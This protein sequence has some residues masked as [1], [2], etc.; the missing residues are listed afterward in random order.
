MMTYSYKKI[1][2]ISWPILFGLIIHQ[3]IGVTD[4]A[5]LGRLGAVELGA[6]ALA[7]V[8]YMMIF[9]VALGFGIGVQIIVARRN[10][11]ADFDKIGIVIYQGTFFLLAAAIFII[12]LTF[13]AAPLLLKNMI[14]SDAVYAKSLNYL[15]IRIFGFLFAFPIV[16]LRSFF[17][18]ITQTKILTWNAIIT[19]IANVVFDYVLIFGKFGFP[20]MGIKGAALASV[21]SE[22]LGTFYFVFY[23]IFYIDFKKYGFNKITIWA[24]KILIKILNL[25][26]WTMLQYFVSMVTWFLFLIAVEHLGEVPLAISNIL[27]SISVFPYM[28]VSALGASANTFTG[29]LIGLKKIDEVIPTSKKIIKIAYASGFVLL[30]I[31]CLFPR[32]ILR[33]YTDDNLLIDQAILPYYASLASFITL[34]PGMIWLSV[35]SGTGRTKEAMY[36]ELI[37]LAVYMVNVWYVVIYLKADLFICWTCDYSYNIILAILTFVYLKCKQWH[38]K[39]V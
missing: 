26:V 10:G 32:A 14:S 22:A 11:E 7:G 12:A 9:M 38:H 1:F 39:T 18:G 35:V 33:I 3:L 24:P 21:I 15:N 29:N 20:E 19:L 13:I 5:F 28:I 37:A 6:S 17:I 23:I 27:R 8:F 34:V 16:I 25:S 31:M 4:T 30:T 2:D 36:M